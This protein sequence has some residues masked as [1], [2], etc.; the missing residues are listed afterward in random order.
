MSR[1][2]LRAL[3]GA[4]LAL[5]ALVYLVLLPVHFSHSPYILRVVSI[6]SVLSVISL[7]VWLTFA[8]GR[9]N[10]GQAAFALI[11]GYATAILTTRF[12]LSYW[13]CLPISGILAALVGTVLGFGILRLR[14]VYFAM[15][16]LSLTEAVR[17]A[18]LNGGEFTGGASGIPIIPLPG[19]LSLFGVVLMPSFQTVNTH[20]AFY[21]L[22]AAL[23]IVTLAVVWRIG[24]S[25][26]G[27]I[28]RSLQQNEDL[29]T[30]I[31]IDIARYRVMAY[32]ICC[33]FGGIGGSY[34]AV[35][36]QSIYP[37]VFGVPDSIFF[38][39][40]CF[41]GGLAYVAGPVVGTFILFIAFQILHPLQEYQQLIYA[42]LMI[43]IMLWLP[44]GLLSLRWHTRADRAELAR[45]EG[46]E[47]RS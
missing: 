39:L 23:L 37:N 25:R 35:S 36:Q 40:Y 18:F 28:F 12:G 22:A 34:F 3:V 44:N 21:Y 7:G 15:I 33:F 14:G 31:G 30:S 6:A 38:I 17:L 1:G 19:E 24:T 42:V 20:L 16:T 29:A 2:L 26:L 9:I 13:L 11:G 46:R 32:A 41:L 47:A 4:G 45:L 10:I 8:I 43:A 27:W 5:L